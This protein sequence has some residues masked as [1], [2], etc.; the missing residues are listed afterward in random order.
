MMNRIELNE[1]ELN[2]VAGGE[3]LQGTANTWYH[4]TPIPAPSAAKSTSL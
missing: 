1:E 4:G 3:D 2:K